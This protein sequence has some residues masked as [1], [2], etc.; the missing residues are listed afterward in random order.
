VS[1]RFA[2]PFT[3]GGWEGWREAFGVL[4]QQEPDTDAC[5]TVGKQLTLKG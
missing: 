1:A 3:G 4:V 5:G 2:G